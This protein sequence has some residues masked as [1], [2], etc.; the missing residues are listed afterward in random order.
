LE[1]RDAEGPR[2]L[3]DV[4]L[5]DVEKGAMEVNVGT[6]ADWPHATQTMVLLRMSDVREDV[7]EG[8][9]LVVA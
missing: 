9:V 3:V 1:V 6:C 4:G 2:G 8:V 7:L 5:G